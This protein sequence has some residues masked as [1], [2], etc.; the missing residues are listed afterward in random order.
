MRRGFLI[1]I[2]LTSAPLFAQSRLASDFEIAQMR[3]LIAT[4][5]DFSAQISARLNLGD[6]HA[7]RHEASI[8]RDEYRRALDL[9]ELQRVSARRESDLTSYAAATAYAGLA[10]AKL[11]RGTAA[12]ALLEESIRYASDSAETWNL[13]ATAMTIL[14]KPQKGARAARNAV[15]IAERDWAHEP[16]T[17]AALD[18][19][20]YR[21]ALATSLIEAGAYDEAEKLLRQVQA[22]LQ[23]PAFDSIRREVD[24]SESFEIYSTARGEAA[25]Y[26]SLLNRSQLRLA[27]LLERR[28]DLTG[29]SATYHRVLEQRTDDPAALAALARLSAA[30]DKDR[31]FVEAFEAN[32]FSSELIRAYREHLATTDAPAG[33]SRT[34]G[35]QVR[36]ALAHMRR[37][38]TRAARVALDDLLARF[39]ASTTVQALREE[40]DAVSTVPSFV[41]TAP[42][43]SVE[44]AAGELRQLM[45]L[46]ATDRLTSDQRAT[47]DAITFNAT[48]IFDAAIRQDPGQTVLES[49]SIDGIPFR[50]SEPVAFSGVFTERTAYRL[51]FRFLGVTSVEGSD[52]LLAEPLRLEE[53]R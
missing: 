45:S 5:R 25:A 41:M 19:A 17:A 22:S 14:Q 52:A 26:L 53:K 50:F 8:A 4:S 1:A 43:T 51:S 44:P 13:Y 32:P 18:L 36:Q 16:S 2:V 35:G 6:L 40:L 15:A 3:K 7:S 9:A 47:L 49:G 48:V 12:Y 46:A 24:R 34:T 11:G 38:E 42:A 21:H 23:T 29:A 27:T 39:P 31:W 28:G 20:V 33:D 30:R 37:G 10:E